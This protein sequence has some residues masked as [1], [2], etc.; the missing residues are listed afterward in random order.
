VLNDDGTVRRVTEEPMHV[1][2]VRS[3]VKRTKPEKPGPAPEPAAAARG[4][5]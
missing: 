3:V 4:S 5:S 2:D 1:D